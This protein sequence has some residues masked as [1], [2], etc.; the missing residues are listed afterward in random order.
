MSSLDR[1]YNKA[2]IVLENEYLHEMKESEM[3]DREA[4][5]QEKKEG[6][7]ES[8]NNYK[9]FKLF[10]FFMYFITVA[11]LF[12]T[13]YPEKIFKHSLYHIQILL[14]TGIYIKLINSINCNTLWYW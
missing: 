7:Y 10:L 5:E 6:F 1:K 13:W 11:L 8:S 4:N 2:E 3:N 12:A 9:F 14:L